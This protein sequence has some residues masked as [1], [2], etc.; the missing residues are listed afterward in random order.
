MALAACSLAMVAAASL[1]YLRSTSGVASG[2]TRNLL[3]ALSSAVALPYSWIVALVVGRR[4]A[5]AAAAGVFCALL[6]LLG[7]GWYAVLL[8][9]LSWGDTTL[10]IPAA[11]LPVQLVALVVALV[12][13]R[14]KTRDG[15]ARLW[16][17]AVGV[18]ILLLATSV[19]TA[20]YFRTRIDQLPGRQAAQAREAQRLLTLGQRCL[21]ATGARRIQGF[22]ER[23]EDVAGSN[24]DCAAALQE[25]T[26]STT[27]RW[28]FLVAPVDARGVRRSFS[29]CGVPKEVPD[30]GRT[31]VVGDQSGARGVAFAPEGARDPVSCADAWGGTI[32]RMA[33]RLQYCLLEYASAHHDSFPESLAD[34]AGESACAQSALRQVA[35]DGPH[36]GLLFGP[37][38]EVRVRYLSGVADSVGRRA[39]Y[40]LFLECPDH[41]GSV[42]IDAQ[43]RIR[44]PHPSLVRHW[45]SGCRVAS[46]ASALPEG[47][48][49]LTGDEASEPW[50]EYAGNPTPDEAAVGAGVVEPEYGPTP[51]LP[52]RRAD[53]QRRA[54]DCYG[55]GRE[56]ERTLR[57]AGANPDH[58]GDLSP[59]LRALWQEGRSAFSRGCAAGSPPACYAVADE[60]L[61][62]C[63]RP[64]DP[65]RAVDLLDRSCSAGHRLS[66]TRLGEVKERGLLPTRRLASRVSVT[67]GGAGG[68]TAT[69]CV[70]D[71]SRP[72][73]A[74]DAGAAIA[75]FAAACRLGDL[76]SCLR[77]NRL[78]L[79]WP[80]STEAQRG[81]ARR[82][83]QRLCDF[84]QAFACHL[85]ADVAGDDV[86]E[87]QLPLE[88]RRRACAL[89][90]DALCAAGG[91]PRSPGALS[92]S[93]GGRPN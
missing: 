56:I 49:G 88:W 53:C 84:G 68:S 75:A 14:A 8:V 85:L 20:L 66:C 36:A 41:E 16:R 19:V 64:E 6:Y 90:D 73:I 81:A 10:W 69:L 4:V 34:V 5:I 54:I 35:A 78:S 40:D 9:L 60:M 83:L 86:V 57:I 2:L 12:M 24:P 63:G 28:T 44:A 31:T 32:P 45:L 87:G 46:R 92:S 27:T 74:P 21:V 51:D 93:S 38:R 65:M 55:L 89:G 17:Q 30:A 26:E 91:A 37:N 70:P 42:V 76:G 59:A 61:A 23:I 13:L 22:P 47:G 58:G 71:R 48:D 62:G 25:M 1:F 67:P 72:P 18:P 39:D 79:Q 77:G 80:G 33:K 82:E 43:S 50:R 11:G 29:L 7:L 3:L 15:A 52:G